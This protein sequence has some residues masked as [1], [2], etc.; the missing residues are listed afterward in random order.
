MKEDKMQKT[1]SKLW[2]VALVL[3][4]TTLPLLAACSSDDEK[5]PEATEQPT[6]PAQEVKIIIGNLSDITGPASNV[7]TVVDAGVKDA[8]KYFTE[9]GLISGVEL[10]M[11]TY[12][13][14]YN[15]SK[16]IPGYKWL[17]ERGSDI[18]IGNIPQT[19]ITLKPFVDDEEIM[20]FAMPYI[21]EGFEPPGY[22]FS[23]NVPTRPLGATAM[24]WIAE[25]DPD[26]PKD[27]PAKI[28]AT[29]WEEPQSHSVY[30]G[31]EA[32]AESHPDQ[33]EWVGGFLT[34]RTF[35]WGSEVE[36]LKD[37]DYVMPP[38]AGLITFSKEY[39]AAGH[40]AKFIG[41]DG[42]SAFLGQIGDARLWDEI[43]GMLFTLPYGY[44]TDDTELINLANQTVR[45][46]FDD[47]Q[48]IIKN[49]TSYLGPFI[50]YQGMLAMLAETINNVGPD[51]FTSQ[52]FYDVANSFSMVLDGREWGFSETK[53]TPIDSIGIYEL[54]GTQQNIF[55]ADP[56]WQPLV[57]F[58]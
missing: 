14:E 19:S 49:G 41:T 42:Q 39:R 27:R 43:D 24:K 12:D 1:S 6:E 16:E 25:N 37:C 52:A 26:F 9:Q 45:E 46:N 35:T 5:T 44:W 17:K 11:I 4:L 38:M 58:E 13:N 33:Y 50:A 7:M 51:N 48:D 18:I 36:A 54:D 15:P 30:D 10:E 22:T 32:Y 28:G 29:N 53:R 56:D 2:M 34:G 31:M 57:T 3:V 47:P 23:L 8:I 21:E 55:R 40:T 20:L